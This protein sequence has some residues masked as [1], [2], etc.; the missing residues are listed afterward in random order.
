MN[1]QQ[2]RYFLAAV[3]HGSFSAAARELRLAQPSVSEQ[4][5]QLE[6]EL[7]VELVARVGRG[8]VPTEAG[9]RFRPEA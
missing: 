4:V 8:L 1:V 7:G 6:A 2:L 3:E 9:R 5:R